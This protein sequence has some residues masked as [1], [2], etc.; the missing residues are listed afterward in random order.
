M[1]PFRVNF[2]VCC[3]TSELQPLGSVFI[4]ALFAKESG[5]TKEK[6]NVLHVKPYEGS[7]THSLGT[8]C[9]LFVKGKGKW[10]TP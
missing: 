8:D 1:H 4:C 6:I 2:S 3:A 7:H 9:Q 5:K 10:V